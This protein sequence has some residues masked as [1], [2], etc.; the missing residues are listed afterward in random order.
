MPML[1]HCGLCGG[2]WFRKIADFG[3]LPL[4]FPISRAASEK[5]IWKERLE[6]QLCQQCS[7]IQTTNKVPL[8]LLRSENLYNSQVARIVSE[9][10]AHFVTAIPQQL[11]LKK[12]AS[13]LEI[14]CGDGSLLK[15]FQ[16][17]GFANVLGLEPAVHSGHRYP[18]E[19]IPE[20]F[21]RASAQKLQARGRLP[22]L[23]ISNYVIELI[24][25][26]EVFFADL[27]FLIKPG[28]HVVL[29]VPYFFDFIERGRI[30][31]FAHLR[32]NWLTIHS[33]HHGFRQNALEMIGVEHDPAYRGGTVRVTAQRTS[34]ASTED[35]PTLRRFLDEEKRK[36]EGFSRATY[37]T[38]LSGL[39]TI[40]TERLSSLAQQMPV[41]GYGGGLKASTLVNFLGLDNRHLAVAFDSDPNKQH[42][43]IPVAN[44]PVEP[45][46]VLFD[47]REPVA[48]VI[49]ALDHADEVEALLCRKLPKGS[50]IIRPLPEFRE[51]AA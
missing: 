36:L 46:D 39:K 24:P 37:Q 11:G 22:D 5:A 28:S 41:F 9:H 49:L 51:V 45:P 7:L 27:A 47:K 48:V 32:C 3:V 12:D 16:E 4:G 26:L 43:L 29:E 18:F 25:N 1:T 14:G 8:D 35:R 19:V 50:R 21:N 20:F 34:S 10:N 31:G 2:G 6:L 13:I 42:K 33:F 38:T 44:V 17:N 23:I 15:R 30:D 40:L